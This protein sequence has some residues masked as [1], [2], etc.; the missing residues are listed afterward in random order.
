MDEL[1]IKLRKHVYERLDIGRDVA[2]SE[3]YEVIDACI[4]DESRNNV[5]SIRQKISLFIPLC[6]TCLYSLKAHHLFNRNKLIVQS[7]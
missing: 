3:L 6:H 4:Y 7:Q 1:Y 2:D 5:I